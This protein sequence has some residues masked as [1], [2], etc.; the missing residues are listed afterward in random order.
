MYLKLI[1]NNPYPKFEVHGKDQLVRIN[2]DLE[3]EAM[4]VT[5]NEKRRVFFIV[6]EKFRK[7]SILTLVNEYSQLLGIL[8]KDKS[9]NS[10]EIEIEGM[11][12]KYKLEDTF[13]K[14]INLFEINNRGVTLNCKIENDALLSA[15]SNINYLLFGL[16]W[17]AFLVKQEKENLQF[18]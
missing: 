9:N 6:E 1:A 2:I 11:K 12:L 14:E 15:S 18:A 10:G 8:I 3:M 13:D 4:R 17:V 5:Y 16:S 7:S